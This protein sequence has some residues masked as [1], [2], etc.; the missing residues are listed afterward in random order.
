MGVLDH[1]YTELSVARATF[2]LTNFVPGDTIYY[3]RAMI[4]SQPIRKP[5][6]SPIKVEKIKCSLCFLLSSD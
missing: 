1:T 5:F 2:V 4:A 6:F 3:Y